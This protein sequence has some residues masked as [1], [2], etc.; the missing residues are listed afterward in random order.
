MRSLSACGQ[1]K[2]GYSLPSEGRMQARVGANEDNEQHRLKAF[3]GYI[4][5]PD[6]RITV[7]ALVL[8]F[9]TR[10]RRRNRRKQFANGY[11][12]SPIHLR[13]D[14]G[15]SAL[16]HRSNFRNSVA[17]DRC[18]RRDSGDLCGDCNLHLDPGLIVHLF[19]LFQFAAENVV[20]VR[21]AIIRGDQGEVTAGAQMIDDCVCHN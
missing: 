5:G 2:S 18:T 20:F 3:D 21:T 9:V 1:V 13:Y 8:M 7:V 10:Q 6:R 12:Q 17:P 15:D 4:R 19:Q 11:V 16:R 14:P